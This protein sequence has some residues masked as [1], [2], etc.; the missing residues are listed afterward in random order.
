[1][2]A[3][4]YR[5]VL[6]LTAA[7]FAV[8]VFA[9]VILTLQ[10]LYQPTPVELSVA[11]HNGTVLIR[12]GQDSVIFEQDCVDVTW[13][14]DR[15]EAVFIGDDATTGTGST[16]YCGEPPVFQVRFQDGARKT[17]T[18]NRD[19]VFSPARGLLLLA[20]AG[21]FLYLVLIGP[22]TFPVNRP[23]FTHLPSWLN[24]Y[25]LLTIIFLLA[26]LAII[27]SNPLNT[28]NDVSLFLQIGAKILDGQRPYVDFFEINLPTIQYLSAIPVLLSRPLTINAITTFQLGMWLL[29]LYASFTSAYLVRRGLSAPSQ[30]GFLI[31]VA[32]LS[33]VT[34]SLVTFGLEPGMPINFGQ[35]EHVFFLLFLPYVLTRWVRGNGVSVPAAVAFGIGFLAAMG[36]TIKPH[37]IVFPVIQ[38]LYWLFKRRQPRSLYA[39]PEIYGAAAFVALALI[40]VTFNFDVVQ[41]YVGSVIPITSAGYGAYGGSSAAS[42]IRENLDLLILV[43]ALVIP[44]RFGNRHTAGLIPVMALLLLASIVVYVSQG[45]GW[46]YHALPIWFAKTI[47]FGLVFFQALKITLGR[48]SY[49]W[50][51][52]ALL[53]PLA[54]LFCVVGLSADLL[55]RA[56][57]HAYTSAILPNFY[58]IILERTQPGDPVLMISSGLSP[59]FPYL[60]IADRR[61]ASRY[62][63]AAPFSLLY[64]NQDLSDVYET[65]HDVPPFMQTYLDDLRED[66]ARNRPNLILLDSSDTCQHCAPGLN[67][68]EY[69]AARNFI[70][71]VIEP[72]YDLIYELDEESPELTIYQRR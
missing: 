65:T 2:A 36:V 3:R 59:T 10:V 46:S 56:S 27:L 18:L 6:R 41:A 48:L 12:S 35:R 72:D 26:M 51:K 13:Q 15:I 24:V 63:V 66:I 28:N 61:Q 23:R 64:H 54:L 34:V 16:A 55:I 9:V 5:S 69:L 32:P 31:W 14:V 52:P 60:Q 68:R 39:Q 22:W 19:V 53:A 20:T 71:D 33:L 50:G 43:L 25:A 70:H 44:T 40:Y 37:F 21:L 42:L 47:V 17:Y 1:M 38:E 62:L 30:N 11:E 8:Q 49:P 58:H 7:F 57:A 4:V 45:K 67:I 29:L